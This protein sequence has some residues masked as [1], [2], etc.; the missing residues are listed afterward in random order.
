MPAATREFLSAGLAISANWWIQEGCIFS[1]AKLLEHADDWMI[2]L[3]TATSER[4]PA[5]NTVRAYLGTL[6][7]TYDLHEI[8]VFARIISVG[9]LLPSISFCGKGYLTRFAVFRF[10]ASLGQCD[11]SEMLYSELLK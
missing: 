9:Y 1:I 3:L 2:K 11:S 7:P 5:C 10:D 6:V 4:V 8:D